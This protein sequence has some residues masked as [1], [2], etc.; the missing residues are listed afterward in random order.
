MKNIPRD[1]TDSAAPLRIELDQIY[2][3]SVVLQIT[4]DNE[5]ITT[6]FDD[7]AEVSVS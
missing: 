4:V 6:S 5:V 3:G 1:T 7:F 2:C